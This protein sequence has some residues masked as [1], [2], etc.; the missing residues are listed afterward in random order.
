MDA[1]LILEIACYS[2]AW[3]GLYTGSWTEILAEGIDNICM[4][5][6][7]KKMFFKSHKPNADFQK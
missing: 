1:D 2:Y 7:M 6:C 4:C 5:F 3:I